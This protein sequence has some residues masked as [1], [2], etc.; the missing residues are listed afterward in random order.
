[1]VSLKFAYGRT[2]NPRRKPQPW[3]IRL[4]R[5]TNSS[6][7]C[8]RFSSQPPWFREPCVLADKFVATILVEWASRMSQTTAAL[9][10]VSLAKRDRDRHLLHFYITPLVQASHTVRKSFAIRE[11]FPDTSDSCV[12]IY[13]DHRCRQFARSLSAKHDR[14]PRDSS[15]CLHQLIWVP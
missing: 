4:I 7:H 12:T 5:V 14:F 2:S 15:E 8:L 13:R 11:P 9:D 1:M 10:H 3:V 6:S